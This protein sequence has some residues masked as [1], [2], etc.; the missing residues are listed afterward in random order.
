MTAP[1]DWSLISGPLPIVIQLAGGAG[2]LWLLWGLRSASLLKVVLPWIAATAVTTA[3]GLY[4]VRRVWRL[5][6]DQLEPTV[7]GWITAAV[8]AI[9]LVIWQT[10]HQRSWRRAIIAALAATAVLATSANQINRHFEAYP[11][12]R[13]VLRIERGIEMPFTEVPHAPTRPTGARPLEKSWHPPAAMP[14]TGQL[15]S[16]PITGTVS[17]FTAR[18]AEI[19]LP[20]AYFTAPR[21]ALPV[22]VL[23]AGQPGGPE[24][25]MTAGR[26]ATLMDRFAAAHHGLAPVVVVA[27]GT[28]SHFDNPL[29]LDSRRGH[30]ATYLA[31]DVPNW[32]TT[33]LTVDPDRTAWAVGGFSYGGTCALQ[34]ATN[35]PDRYPTFL[36]IS[37]Q[38]EPSLGDRPGTIDALF[39]GNEAAFTRVNPLDLLRAHT[40]P[41]S[42][43]AL[44][45]GASDAE[46]QAD[47][48][49]ILQATRTAGMDT[50]HT[51]VAGRHDWGAAR[52]A[53]TQELPWLA[54]RMGLTN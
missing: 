47:A 26:L 52:A 11:A 27:D 46:S 35:Y 49:K 5:F 45:V 9:L 42:A 29:C 36:D 48:R 38:A 3:L 22:L 50:H 31:I 44:V 16:A 28:G 54:T 37:G 43:G 39:G 30:A 40:Y 4:A 21:P 33:H 25:W 24:D 19:Y 14:A 18:P 6:P 7:Y 20:P 1:L 51:Q 53:L 13:D 15:T 8:S 17:G 2:A 10:I 12:V 34:L 23:L 41:R 32:I